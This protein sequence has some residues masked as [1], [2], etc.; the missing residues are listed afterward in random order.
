VFSTTTTAAMQPHGT[1]SSERETTAPLKA[2]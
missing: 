2:L 1:R